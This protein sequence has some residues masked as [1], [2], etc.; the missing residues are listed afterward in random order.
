[1]NQLSTEYFL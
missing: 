1:M